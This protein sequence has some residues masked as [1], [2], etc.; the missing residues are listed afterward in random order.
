[1]TSESRWR[2]RLRAQQGNTLVLFPAAIIILL[3]LGALALDAATIYLGQRRLADLAAAT[4]NDAVG[5]L[6]LDSF[7]DE[8]QE[9]ELEDGLGTQRA[10]I[11]GAQMGEDRSFEN[12]TCEVAVDALE[13]TASC[14]AQVRPILAPFWPGLGDRLEIRAVESARAAEGPLP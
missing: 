8:E 4:A 6:R 14:T 9:P 1:M 13:A 7:Y 11:I 5:G 2:E 12:V 3:G 10:E